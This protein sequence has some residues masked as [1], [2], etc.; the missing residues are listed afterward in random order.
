MSN[1]PGPTEMGLLVIDIDG[2]APERRAVV[3]GPNGYELWYENH[4]GWGAVLNIAGG[5]Y[6]FGRTMGDHEVSPCKEAQAHIAT[7]AKQI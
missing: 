6:Q 2:A 3:K 4:A 1:P 7:A 5:I